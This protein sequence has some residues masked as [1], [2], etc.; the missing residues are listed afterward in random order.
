MVATSYIKLCGHSS[1]AKHVNEEMKEV[2]GNRA[3][4]GQLCMTS[5]V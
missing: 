5:V 4:S 2:D 3:S 1:L